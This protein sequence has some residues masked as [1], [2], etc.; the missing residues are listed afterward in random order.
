MARTATIVSTLEKAGDV[1]QAP[2]ISRTEIMVDP[3]TSVSATSPSSATKIG[4]SLSIASEPDNAWVAARQ[5]KITAGLLALKEASEHGSERA[6]TPHDEADDASVSLD[7][8]HPHRRQERD[9][10]TGR[11]ATEEHALLSGESERI[12]TQNFDENTPFGDRVAII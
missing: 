5:S 2:G 11:E 3:I 10:S 7:D 1:H 6:P 12:G 8:R 4:S 9:A